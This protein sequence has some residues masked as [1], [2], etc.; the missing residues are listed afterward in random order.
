M[1][2]CMRVANKISLQYTCF[3]LFIL[4]VITSFRFNFPAVTLLFRIVLTTFEAC[5]LSEHPLCTQFV[6]ANS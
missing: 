4:S 2:Y 5:I 6:I 1:Q 3:G